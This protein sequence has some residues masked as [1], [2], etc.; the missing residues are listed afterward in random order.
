MEEHMVRIKKAIGCLAVVV[1]G[2]AVVDV[3]LWLTDHTELA[4]ALVGFMVALASFALGNVWSAMLM[5]SGSELTI[6]SQESDDQRDIAQIRAATD[7]VKVL[8]RRDEKEQQA[9]EQQPKLPMPQ[10][11]RWLPEYPVDGEFAELPEKQER[12]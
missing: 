8:L 7:L 6:R 9:Q 2:F 5:K 12:R 11:Q 3:G 4:I 1:V 10:Q